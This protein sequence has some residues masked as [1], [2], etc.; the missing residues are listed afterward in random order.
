MNLLRL[1]LGIL[2]ATVTINAWLIIRTL[3]AAW[4]GCDAHWAA[5]GPGGAWVETHSTQKSMKVRILRGRY[6][7]LT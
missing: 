7:R 6:L 1:T 4:R 3:R 5:G 2:T